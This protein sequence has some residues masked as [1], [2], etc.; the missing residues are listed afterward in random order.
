MPDI[1]DINFDQFA[2]DTIPPD[3]RSVSNVALIRG[4]LRAAQWCRNLILGTYKVGFVP[5]D[6][7]P[8]AYNKYDQVVYKQVVY[9]SLVAS[10]SALPTDT[11]K[12]RIIQQNFIGADERIKFNGT[13]LIAE[14]A[15]N[16]WFET[17][18]RQ[19]PAVSDIYLTTNLV[20]APVFRF[21]L[22]ES[23]SSSVGRTTSSEFVGNNYDFLD[24]HNFSI[25]MPLAVYDALDSNPANRDAIVRNFFDKYVTV[26]IF[27]NIVTY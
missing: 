17:N 25:H 26:G 22:T 6:Y 4:L 18:F 15:L 8:G 23:V 27:Y 1:F 19:P 24:V 20:S 2:V 16:K 5:G 21:G 13:K 11:T 12:W 3:K 7:S 9:E 10:N 14:Y